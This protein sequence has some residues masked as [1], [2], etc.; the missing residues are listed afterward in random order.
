M[1]NTIRIFAISFC[2][3][4]LSFQTASAQ[5]FLRDAE[6]EQFLDDYSRPVFEVAGLPAESVGIHI[7]GDP[8]LNA[9]VANGLNMYVFTGLIT[10]AEVPNQILGVIAH[11]TGHLAGGHLQ[12]S[13]SAIA[14]AS[15]PVMLSMVLGTVAI[16]SGSS[17]VGMGIFA[18]GQTVGTAEFLSYS[19]GQESSADQAALTYLEDLGQSPVG[20]VDFFR[21]PRNRQ[22][23]TYDRAVPYYSTHPLPISRMNSLE[24]RVNESA[25]KDQQDSPE[26]IFRLKMIQAKINGFMRPANVTLRQYPLADKSQ[27]A[28]YARAVAYYRSSNLQKALKEIDSL[29]EEQPDNPFFHELKGQMLF[30]HGK[31][32]DSV[33]PHRRSTELAPKYALLKVNYARA[34]VA[35]EERASTT[36][37]IDILKRALN[38]EPKNIFGWTEL[39]RA[40][41]A[42]GRDDLAA[43][44]TAEA[45]FNAGVMHEAHRFATRASKQLK[46]GSMEWRQANDIIQASVVGAAKFQQKNGSRKRLIEM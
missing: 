46:E 29:I 1:L 18:L 33:G 2:V 7:I 36:E 11:E 12:R 41:S 17:D 37:A 35:L 3:T 26:E 10:N 31:I 9:F 42:S 30:E 38:M 24:R 21:K 8:S 27:P 19:R 22:L 25:V 28:R 20:L 16:L 6:I 44:A 34:L 4:I 15:R 40:Y 13:E 5:S 23:T 32:R 43:L 39:A 45:Y 14:A